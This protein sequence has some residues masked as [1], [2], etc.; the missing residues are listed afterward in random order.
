MSSSILIIHTFVCVL[1]VLCDN[2]KVMFTKILP[3]HM[4][5]STSAAALKE[6]V[7]YEEQNARMKIM[8]LK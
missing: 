3:Y 4:A 7:L 5:E 2:K 1:D 8:N 6:L